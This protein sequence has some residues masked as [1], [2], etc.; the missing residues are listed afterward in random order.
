M[1]RPGDLTPGR[2][3]RGDFYPRW[4]RIQVE[5][6]IYRCELQLYPNRR[7]TVIVLSCPQMCVPAMTLWYYN[8]YEERKTEATCSYHTVSCTCG[9]YAKI[10]ILWVCTGARIQTLTNPRHDT[11]SSC[12]T[13]LVWHP[14]ANLIECRDISNWRSKGN[15]GHVHNPCICVAA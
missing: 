3:R 5:W 6:L 8:L 12:S 9:V 15:L 11:R 7:R 13:V 2:P 10:E 14:S 4:Q 1:P